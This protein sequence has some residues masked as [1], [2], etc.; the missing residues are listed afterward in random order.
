MAAAT[1]RSLKRSLDK[2]SYHAIILSSANAADWNGLVMLRNVSLVCFGGIYIRL[3]RSVSQQIFRS[4]LTLKVC[5]IKLN[6]MK[7][8]A[9]S[10]FN[11]LDVKGF[12][13]LALDTVKQMPH[14]NAVVSISSFKEYVFTLQNTFK[15]TILWRNRHLVL[16]LMKLRTKTKAE[17]VGMQRE[18]NKRRQM[19]LSQFTN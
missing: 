11:S 9:H 6:A 18:F 13:N 10:N 16:V 12:F 17:I 8:Y 5:A 1:I 4:E 3:F 14:S 2:K 15:S 19:R 7:L